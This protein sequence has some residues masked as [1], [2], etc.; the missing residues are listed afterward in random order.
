MPD[1]VRRVRHALRRLLAPWLSGL[2]DPAG[3]LLQVID[4]ARPVGDQKRVDDS[5][6]VGESHLL[7]AT[8]VTVNGPRFVPAAP[9]R[10][11]NDALA[12]R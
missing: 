7:K 1:L 6:P 10:V 5:Q 11:K 8:A 12:V 9:V 3:P 2:N 4:E